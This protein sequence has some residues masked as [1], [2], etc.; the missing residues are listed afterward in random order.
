MLLNKL[1]FH[2]EGFILLQPQSIFPLSHLTF[3]LNLILQEA[4]S[5][6]PWTSAG[7]AGVKIPYLTYL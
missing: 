4:D 7:A 6:P 1:F 5:H 2:I 3:L